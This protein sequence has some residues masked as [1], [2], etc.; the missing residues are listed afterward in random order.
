MHPAL[1]LDNGGIQCT[2]EYRQHLV[3]EVPA[4]RQGIQE[5]RS[6][7]QTISHLF[8]YKVNC[9]AHNP[10]QTYLVQ[11]EVEVFLSGIPFEKDG[12]VKCVQHD[13]RKEI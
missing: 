9:K 8:A 12:K 7:S 4:P 1:S 10:S 11:P 13:G 3:S 6:V 2:S 5:V